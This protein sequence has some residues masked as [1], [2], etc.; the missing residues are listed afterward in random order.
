M[1][2]I[3]VTFALQK[4]HVEA[5]AALGSN[6]NGCPWHAVTRNRAAAELGYTDN[7]GNFV[8]LVSPWW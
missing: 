7:F 4:C 6:E 5:H 3:P 1:S 2:F 8:G